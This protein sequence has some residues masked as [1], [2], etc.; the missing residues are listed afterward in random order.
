MKTNSVQQT[1]SRGEPIRR[2]VIADDGG[3]PVVLSDSQ[4]HWAFDS[5]PAFSNTLVWATPSCPQTGLHP[6]VQAPVPKQTRFLP[7]AGGTSF[8]IVNFPPDA[9][10]ME[11]KVDGQA[12]GAELLQRMPGLADTF[13]A[14]DPVM[15]VTD[16]VDYGMV[17]EGE[18]WLDLGDQEVH[19]KKH[20]V[21]VQHGARHGWRNKG[22]S[23]ATMLFVLIGA[24]PRHRA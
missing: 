3:K 5:W 7:E 24:Q 20:D 8:M 17:L 6:G 9:H 13:E 22:Q 10:L 23:S 19:L 4:E 1:E 11:G 18:I 2:V 12:F 14:E 16:T 21:V 15:H